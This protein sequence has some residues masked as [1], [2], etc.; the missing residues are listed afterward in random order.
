MAF[1]C[2]SC[3]RCAFLESCRG[4]PCVI[5][6]EALLYLA[7]ST[8]TLRAKVSILAGAILAILAGYWAALRLIPVPGFGAGRLDSLGNLPGYID[9]AVFGTIICGL[10]D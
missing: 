2:F 3:T 8:K 1:R 5:S 9:R 6:A 7:C 10:T 4:S